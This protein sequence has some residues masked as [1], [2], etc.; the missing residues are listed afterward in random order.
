MRI[1]CFGAG[2]GSTAMIVEL[3]RRGISFDAV[4]FA[5]TG[6]E[7]PETIEHVTV[8]DK[9]LRAK[10]LPCVTVVKN[11][12]ET[13]EERCLRLHALP[14]LAYGC[15]RCTDHFKIRPMHRWIKSQ[16]KARRALRQGERI[17]R[18]VGFDIEESGRAASA[19]KK[20]PRM[21]DEQYPLIRFGVMR[22]E[23]VEICESQG[24][25]VRK[26]SCWCCPA[27]KKPEILELAEKHPNLASRAIAIE[28]N[29]RLEKLAGLGRRWNWKQFLAAS[30][31]GERRQVDGNRM[32]DS[33]GVRRDV[34]LARDA[35]C[36][37][38]LRRA[39]PV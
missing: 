10:G 16:P 21:Y 33:V 32:E 28:S 3:V 4:L 26:S 23:A 25:S 7:W 1:V 36:V 2:I 13:L 14:A 30:E 12:K 6:C 35:L 22:W 18:Y 20:V 39:R 5:D 11:E 27:M 34:G 17:V 38:R 37:Y 15:R 9:W 29:A 31:D 8:V 19:S 24:W